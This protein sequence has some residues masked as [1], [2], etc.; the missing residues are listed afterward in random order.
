[1]Y[2][3]HCWSSAENWLSAYPD[4]T[5]CTLLESHFVVD[6]RTTMQAYAGTEML[7]QSA[8]V[9]DIC[10]QN[11]PLSSMIINLLLQCSPLYLQT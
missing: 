4:C 3:L 2:V 10:L 6:N 7:L 8:S 11:T 9:L 5:M 1:M